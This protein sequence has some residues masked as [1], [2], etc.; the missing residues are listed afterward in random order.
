MH[1]NTVCTSELSLIARVE[2]FVII[3]RPWELHFSKWKVAIARNKVEEI[4]VELIAVAVMY[5]A[6]VTICLRR[7]VISD[8]CHR[9][10]R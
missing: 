1:T 6:G 5:V 8:P 2:K 4:W 9:I 7:R 3:V 10:R